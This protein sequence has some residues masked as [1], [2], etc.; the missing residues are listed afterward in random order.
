MDRKQQTVKRTTFSPINKLKSYKVRNYNF[1]LL[2]IMLCLCAL[3]LAIIGSANAGSDSKAIY[4]QAVGMIIGFTGMFIV[5]LLDYNF[6]LKFYWIIYAFNAGLLL[7]VLKFGSNHKGAQRW[8]DII[9]TPSF[10]LTLQPSEFAKIFLILFFA[11]FLSNNRERV[12]KWWFLFVTAALA[13]IPLALIVK[14]PDLSTTILITGL[15]CVMIYAA[16]LSYKKILIILAVVV[17]VIVGFLIYVQQPDYDFDKGPLKEYQVNRILS[18]VN[19]AEYDDLR[20]QQDNSVIAI[21]SGKLSGKGLYNDSAE[22]LKNANQLSEESVNDFIFAIIGEELGFIGSCAVL[23]LLFLI[24]FEC[25]YAAI[26]APDM[27]G[28][29]I[30]TGMAMLLTIQ[31]FINVGVATEILPNTGIP[32]PFVSSG[33]SSLLSLFG[34]MGFVFNV[35]LQRDK[36]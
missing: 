11:K 27:T 15:L 5:S 22:S 26:K 2:F 3:G 30:C 32:L 28:R 17:P 10:Q 21:G 20:W 33:L 7:T 31:T 8:I 13:A 35:S 24:I 1:R 6:V 19:P 12:S 16:G 9:K 34:G 29:M 23:G 14:E 36:A 4:K 25:F 18:F